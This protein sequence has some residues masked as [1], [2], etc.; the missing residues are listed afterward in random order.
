MYDHSY[1]IVKK[2][3]LLILM[4]AVIGK[5]FFRTITV[6]IYK[7]ASRDFFKN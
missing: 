2:I 1:L 7:S 3:L 5:Y 4:I 6:T